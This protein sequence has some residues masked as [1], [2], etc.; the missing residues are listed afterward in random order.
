MKPAGQIILDVDASLRA[1]G[2]C[3]ACSRSRD[4]RRPDRR[5]RGPWRR[6]RD[7]GREVCIIRR[8][9]RDC[10][11]DLQSERQA[12]V[13]QREQLAAMTAHEGARINT[14]CRPGRRESE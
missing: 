10:C 11:R 9:G 6:C 3:P 12:W 8:A 5:I 7:C 2:V 4:H 1:Q 14:K 13:R